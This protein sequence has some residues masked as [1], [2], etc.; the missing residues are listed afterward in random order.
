MK[1]EMFI[2]T[3]ILDFETNLIEDFYGGNFLVTYVDSILHTANMYDGVCKITLGTF[4][5]NSYVQK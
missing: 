5:V 4:A 3:Q 1:I 2:V